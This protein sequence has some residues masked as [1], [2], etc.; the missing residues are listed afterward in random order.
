MLS[1]FP[2]NQELVSDRAKP[3]AKS[4][5]L[6]SSYSFC[7]LTTHRGKDVKDKYNLYP[8]DGWLEYVARN[9][10]YLQLSLKHTYMFR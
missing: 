6:Q 3:E 9:E 7:H 5:R 10:R 8:N 2:G 4:G 1:D